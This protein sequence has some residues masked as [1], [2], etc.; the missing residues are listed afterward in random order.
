MFSV[1]RDFCWQVLKNTFGDTKVYSASVLSPAQA[2]AF[3]QSKASQKWLK[4][5]R[6]GIN[7]GAAIPISYV[8]LKT[9]K[10]QQ[11]A[12]ARPITSY[13]NCILGKL[14]RAASSVLN[15]LLPAVYPGSFGLQALPEAFQE[16]RAFLSN[17]PIDIYICISVTKIC[18]AFYKPAH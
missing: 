18:W 16:L 15:K 14:F 4:P 12:V 13:S 10:K 8:L 11:F 9:K 7:K 5:Y 3:L 2:N 1:C 17:A 6:R